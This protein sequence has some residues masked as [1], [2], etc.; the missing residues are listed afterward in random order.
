MVLGLQ[1]LPKSAPATH[2]SREEEK[3]PAT[4]R[5]REEEEEEDDDD[6]E[7]LP[8]A[9]SLNVLCVGDPAL[10]GSRPHADGDLGERT[11]HA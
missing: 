11:A 6:D 8:A 3:F 2:R 9:E 7:E 5:S 4:H 1:P 10:L